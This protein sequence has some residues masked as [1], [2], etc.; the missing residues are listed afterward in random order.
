MRQKVEL[1]AVAAR[2]AAAESVAVVLE[3]LERLVAKEAARGVREER[4]V[5]VELTEGV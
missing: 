4:E 1:M 5:M 2:G 3:G